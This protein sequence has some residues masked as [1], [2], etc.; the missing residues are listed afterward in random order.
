LTIYSIE[1][2]KVNAFMSFA[3]LSRN[4]ATVHASLQNVLIGRPAFDWKI[5]A[6]LTTENSDLMRKWET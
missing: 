6:G 2:L 3:R 4:G 5:E 1:E